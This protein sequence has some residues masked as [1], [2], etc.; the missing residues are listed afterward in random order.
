[1]E[2]GERRHKAWDGMERR[3]GREER[4][5][6]GEK[7]GE[8]REEEIGK[9]QKERGNGRKKGGWVRERRREKGKGWVGRCR[10]VPTVMPSIVSCTMH[11]L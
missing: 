3:R 6:K 7:N 1:M 5:R 2:E 4:R 11:S 9:G 8:K 10:R